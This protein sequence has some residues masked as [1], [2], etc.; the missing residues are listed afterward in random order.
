MAINN[1]ARKHYSDA[2]EYLRIADDASDA[3]TAIACTGMGQLAMELAKFA[4]A[5]HALVT[6]IDEGAA[7][8]QPAN[9]P[10]I[11]QNPQ[12]PA[13]MGGPKLWGGQQ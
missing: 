2:V 8:P 12:S 13:P 10:G 11:Q 7:E 6:G 5:N 9:M 3:T 4:V 1:V